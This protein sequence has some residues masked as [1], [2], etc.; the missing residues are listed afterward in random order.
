MKLKIS[1]QL[2]KSRWPKSFLMK[3]NKRYPIVFF[4]MLLAFIA[5]TLL[6]I[7]PV[8]GIRNKS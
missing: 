3:K 4:K 1:I 7:V 8:A 2:N 5:V 6:L